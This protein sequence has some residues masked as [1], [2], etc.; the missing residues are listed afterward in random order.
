MLCCAAWSWGSCGVLCRQRSETH[1]INPLGGCGQLFTS[2]FMSCC[3]GAGCGVQVLLRAPPGAPA[4]ISDD[5]VAAFCFPSG[6]H[7]LCCCAGP[8]F[9]PQLLCWAHCQ[10][11]ACVQCSYSGGMGAAWPDQHQHS[12]PRWHDCCHAYELVAQSD[13]GG[14]WLVLA[15]CSRHPLCCL[16]CC[17]CL[18][19]RVAAATG[20]APEKLRRTPSLSALDELVMGRDSDQQQQCFVFMLKVGTGPACVSHWQAQHATAHL[21]TACS[22][23]AQPAR[24]AV[25]AQDSRDLFLGLLH[26]IQLNVRL[27]AHLSEAPAQ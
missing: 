5:E 24:H 20:V 16:W 6:K 11:D 25:S 15:G 12:G 19:M 22:C 21:R 17:L 3:H 4:P 8:I 18:C 1:S 14:C 10:A 13:C 26:Y 9:R 2:M 23:T 27:A 7:Q